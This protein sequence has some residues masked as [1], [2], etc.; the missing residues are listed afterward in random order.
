MA[1]PGAAA[2]GPFL[3]CRVMNGGARFENGWKNFKPRDFTLPVQTRLHVALSPVRG[4]GE[5]LLQAYYDEAGQKMIFC[6]VVE[7]PP[8]KKVACASLYVL[9]DDL[10]MGVKRTLDVP[11]AVQGA[12]ISCALDVEKIKK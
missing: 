7:G 6:P 1:A 12:N 10:E 3:Y 8:G 9:Q 5:M 11:R 4:A 2:E